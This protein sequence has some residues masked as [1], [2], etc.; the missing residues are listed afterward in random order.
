[1]TSLEDL[2][3]KVFGNELI[4]LLV[5]HMVYSDARFDR[6]GIL[7][8]GQGAES[9]LGRLDRLMNDQV[10]RPEDARNFTRIVHGFHRPL[11]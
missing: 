10:L 2:N 5:T 3:T 4:F 7:N 1:M 9:F 6:Y 11:T 8:L